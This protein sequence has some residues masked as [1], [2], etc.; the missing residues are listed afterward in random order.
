MERLIPNLFLIGAP[1]AGTTAMASYLDEHPQIF[2]CQPKEPDYFND[3]F[4]NRYATSLDF[5]LNLFARAHPY[6]KYLLDASTRYLQSKTAIQRILNF[7]PDSKFIVML[8]N[9]CEMAPALHAQYLCEGYED[10]MNFEKA[11]S[12]ELERRQLKHI[13]AICIEPK[14][15]FYREACLIGK[16]M[17]R[18]YRLVPHERVHVIIFD[19]FCAD[20]KVEYERVLNFLDLE[21]YEKT[22]FEKMNPRKG[23]RYPTFQSVVLKLGNLKRLMGIQRGLGIYKF[24]NRFNIVVKSPPEI[25]VELKRQMCDYFREDVAL[26]SKLINRDLSHWVTIT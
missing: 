8:R 3:D 21:P 2:A 20:P 10:E 11:W 24:I 7:N 6:Y 13:P 26:L 5:Y 9:P 17:E 25:S 14:M 18:L 4:V 15:L 19:D 12:I 16:H 1:K 22:H 23:F